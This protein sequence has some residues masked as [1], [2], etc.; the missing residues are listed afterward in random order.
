VSHHL[1][2]ADP[3]GAGQCETRRVEEVVV[4]AGGDEGES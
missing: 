1:G 3:A 4:V 2:S